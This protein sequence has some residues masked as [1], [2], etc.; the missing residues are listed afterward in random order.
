MLDGTIFNNRSP[1]KLAQHQL[2]VLDLRLAI[3]V[4]SVARQLP[5]CRANAN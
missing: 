4:G 1:G 5:L 3:F 2:D